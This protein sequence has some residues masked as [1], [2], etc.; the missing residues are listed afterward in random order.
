VARRHSS[1][2]RSGRSRLR[3]VGARRRRENGRG[4]LEIGRHGGAAVGE[5]AA[6]A[7]DW[8][9]A[10]EAKF[11]RHFAKREA[12]AAERGWK[13]VETEIAVCDCAFAG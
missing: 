1:P 4:C 5:L 2:A 6:C 7:G 3:G 9:R 13:K 8:R 11:Q 10:G 12:F